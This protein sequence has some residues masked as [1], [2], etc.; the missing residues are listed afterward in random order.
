ME[1]L[2]TIDHDLDETLRWLDAIERGLDEFDAECDG[3]FNEVHRA[4]KRVPT[5]RKA[6]ERIREPLKE[7][8]AAAQ[9]EYD[10]AEA[11]STL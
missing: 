9:K 7:S 10:L 6:L 4:L 3:R 11:R 5:A 1:K 8:I 2:L